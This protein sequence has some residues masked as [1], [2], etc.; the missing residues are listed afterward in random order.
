MGTNIHI[1]SF[2]KNANLFLVFKAIFLV[3]DF[4]GSYLKIEKNPKQGFVSPCYIY[5]VVHKLG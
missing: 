3:I 1:I 2:K 4:R 5:E